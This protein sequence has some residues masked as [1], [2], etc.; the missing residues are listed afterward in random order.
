MSFV[1]NSIVYVLRPKKLTRLLRDTFIGIIDYFQI[2]DV[3]GTFQRR[4]RE[5]LRFIVVE[6]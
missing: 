2:S 1:L 6:R 4:V 5:V 3:Y